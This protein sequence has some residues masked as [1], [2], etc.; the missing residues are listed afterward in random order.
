MSA[1]KIN[2]YLTVVVVAA[3][4]VV[5]AVVVN[6]IDAAAI[7]FQRRQGCSVVFIY[8]MFYLLIEKQGS[9]DARKQRSKKRS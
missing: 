3:A 9:K 4:V 6:F 1:I 8:N 5:T 2:R 7:F